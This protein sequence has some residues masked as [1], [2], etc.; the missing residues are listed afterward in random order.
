MSEIF[1]F[2]LLGLFSGFGAGLFGI[3]GGSMSL[4]ILYFLLKHLG[5]PSDTLMQ[6]V[7]G[8]T[9]A[10]MSLNAFVSMLSH[11]YLGT[12]DWKAIKA[13]LPGFILGPIIGA[14]IASVLHSY[15]LRIAFGIVQCLLAAYLLMP[16]KK[17]APVQISK[18]SMNA[19]SFGIG[20][21][22][23]ILGIGGGTFLAPFL[24]YLQFPMQRAIGTSAAG[25][26]L[27]IFLATLCYLFF[28]HVESHEVEGVF[29]FLYLPAF[30]PLT[31][32]SVIGAVIG[33]YFMKVAP[34]SP[35]RRGFAVV[36]A[37]FGLTLI[38]G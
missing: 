28:G 32:S 33:A 5:L 10:A 9:F 18:V 27:M 7:I 20:T 2:L 29:G 15:I 24:L 16:H 12:I 11:Q 3:G 38:F 22:G 4:P 19:V 25:S 37:L 23:S 34:L 17:S 36:Q 13:M 1:I 26:F 31:I 35:L 21:V 8:T 30:F 6:I 14:F